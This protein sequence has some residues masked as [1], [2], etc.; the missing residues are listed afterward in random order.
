MILAVV[1]CSYNPDEGLD[2]EMLVSRMINDRMELPIN[3]MIVDA[4]GDACRVIV[5]PGGVRFQ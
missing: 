4:V 1:R 2:A 3:I 5:T